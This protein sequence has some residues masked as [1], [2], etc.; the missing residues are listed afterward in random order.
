MKKEKRK[1]KMKGKK[2]KMRKKKKVKKK[3]NKKEKEKSVKNGSG[4]FWEVP[5]TGQEKGSQNR[6]PVQVLYSLNGPA[7]CSSIG[8]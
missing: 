8:S 7:Q 3:K 2:K 6:R 5:E 1:T 4:T